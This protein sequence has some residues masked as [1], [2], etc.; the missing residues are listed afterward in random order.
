MFTGIIEEV[1]VVAQ[2]GARMKIHCESVLADSGLGASIAV[3]G[4]CLTAVALTA[5][6]FEMDLSPETLARTNLGDLRSGDPVNLERPLRIGGRLDG[7]IVQGHVDGVA[8]VV[9][10]TELPNGNW[11]Y[12]VRVPADL[13]RYMI[14]KGSVCLDGI[15][16]TIAQ[17]EAGVLS[18]AIIPHTYAQT[19]LR[20]RTPGDRVN[21]EVDMIAK[22]VEK[23]TLPHQAR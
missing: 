22:Y 5:D 1:G 12:R 8:E 20:R 10:L 7:H 3:N 6:A 15:S 2:P 9:A 17:L 23:L 13:E 21:V 14:H 18:V 4:T 16:L 19:N 11:W